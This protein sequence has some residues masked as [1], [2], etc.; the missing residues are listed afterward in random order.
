MREIVRETNLAKADLIYPI[1]IKE[2]LANGNENATAG[3]KEA[4]KTMPDEY[5]YSL[6]TAVDYAGELEDKGLKSIIIFGLP[7][8]KDETGSQAYNKEGIVQKA[9]RELKNQT[10]L[11]VMSDVCLC[12]YTSHGHCGIVSNEKI[13]NDATLDLLTKVA[14]SHA[15]AGVDLVAPSDMMDGRV[16]AIRNGLDSNGFED[17]IIM[18]YSAKYASAFYGPFRDA[19]SSA[20]SF[21][22]RKSYQMDIN[23]GIEAIREAELDLAEGADILMVKPAMAYGDII[24][25]LKDNFKVPIAAYNVSGE[26]SMIKSAISNGYLG[27]D[28]ILETLISIKRSGADLILSHFTK[29]VLD[30]L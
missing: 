22:D 26:Y 3:G 28:A 11:T 14:V 8:N 10:N 6:D 17:T 21:G 27:E 30:K 29:D 5:R 25:A 20:P 13:Q 18:S 2:D 24:K 7:S 12:Q 1:F 15:E 16:G 4:I 23:N 19:V 9:I